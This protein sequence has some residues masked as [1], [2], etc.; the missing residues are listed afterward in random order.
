MVHLK[1]L[2]SG[3]Q[4]VNVCSCKQIWRNLA[5][6]HLLNN[7]TSAVN[8][9][10]QNESPMDYGLIFFITNMLFTNFMLHKMLVLF[11]VMFYQ[12][13]GLSFWRHPF[14]AE[15][16]LLSKWCNATFLQ[17]FWWRNR[18]I[19]ILYRLSTFSA[20]FLFF[21]TMKNTA[22]ALKKMSVFV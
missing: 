2:P 1:W 9:C 21:K 17:I 18:L 14:T 10:R 16:P 5:F 19:F 22:L 4:D 13:F 15:D 6:H 12:L 20:Y 7:G 3:H 11:I 8:G